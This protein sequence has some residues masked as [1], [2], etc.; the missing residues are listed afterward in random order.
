MNKYKQKYM[1]N[2]QKRMNSIFSGY[3]TVTTHTDGNLYLN[4]K[5]KCRKI[6]WID[7]EYFYKN[8]LRILQKKNVLLTIRSSR[9]VYTDLECH[10]FCDIYLICDICV[11]RHTDYCTEI[12]ILRYPFC[13][14]LNVLKVLRSLQGCIKWEIVGN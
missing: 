3:T 5:K 2:S 7:W 8:V 9:R 1:I 13:S 6:V 14:I 10:V 4:L 12:D 11:N